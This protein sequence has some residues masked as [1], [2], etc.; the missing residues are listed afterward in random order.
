MPLPKSLLP[1]PK[2][3]LPLP[4]PLLPLPLPCRSI[5]PSLCPSVGPSHFAFFVF[6]DYLEVEKHISKYLMSP[7]Q[8]LQSLYINQ[9]V[10]WSFSWLVGL[11]VGPS[12]SAC[13]LF[14]GCTGVRK[15]TFRYFMETLSIFKLFSSRRIPPIQLVFKVKSSQILYVCVSMGAMNSSPLLNRLD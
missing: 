11:S 14:L 4:K 9:S 8:H 2:S 13:F 6:L 12:K 15:Y 1:L 5:R 7:K 3:L 10:I